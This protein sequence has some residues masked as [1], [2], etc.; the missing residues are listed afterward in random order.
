MVCE[1]GCCVFLHVY[2][3]RTRS[4]TR[5]RKK[6]VTIVRLVTQAKLTMCIY[7]HWNT[8][9]SPQKIDKVSLKSGMT[10]WIQGSMNPP[11]S[12][13]Q[14]RRVRYSTL[15]SCLCLS[16]PLSSYRS[17]GKKSRLIATSVFIQPSIFFAKA[18]ELAVVG[19]QVSLQFNHLPTHASSQHLESRAYR[20]PGRRPL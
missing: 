1:F 17:A 2:Y 6:R 3:R 9:P 5:K 4:T 8:S 18:A 11:P 20:H 12:T 14:L 7:P 19:L 10:I 15:G 13:P 16:S